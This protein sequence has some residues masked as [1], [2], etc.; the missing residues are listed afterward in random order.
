MDPASA[1]LLML[2]S[3][4]EVQLLSGSRLSLNKA[5]TTSPNPRCPSDV[6]RRERAEQTVLLLASFA[7][8][9]TAHPSAHPGPGEDCGGEQEADEAESVK[10]PH[11]PPHW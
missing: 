4:A 7:A 3:Q 2:L 5:G 10:G 6:Q 9:Q 8:G 11:P 1:V